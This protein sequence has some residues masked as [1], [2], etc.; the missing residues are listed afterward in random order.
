MSKIIQRQEYTNNATGEVET[1]DVMQQNGDFN[2]EK[3]WLGHLMQTLDM[4]GN[5]KI[6]VITYILT[7]RAKSNNIFIGSQRDIAKATGISLRTISMTIKALKEVDF[8]QEIKAGVYQINPDCIFK[9]HK[10]QRMNIVLQYNKIDKKKKD[11]NKEDQEE[12]K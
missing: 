11:T 2:F 1:F 8:I 4:I 7:N 9:G 5:Q 12:I 3:I 10:G 6:K